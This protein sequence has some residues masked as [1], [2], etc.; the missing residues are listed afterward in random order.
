MKYKLKFRVKTKSDSDGQNS[1]KY[2]VNIEEG[3]S[4]TLGKYVPG[5]EHPIAGITMQNGCIRANAKVENEDLNVNGT[6]GRE[7]TLKPNDV[8]KAGD[9]IVEFLEVPYRQP[10]NP[11]NETQVLDLG[12]LAAH[13]EATRIGK[14]AQPETHEK[15]TAVMPRGAAP[16]VANQNH[17]EATIVRPQ[18]SE[19]TPEE[20]R[21]GVEERRIEEQRKDEQ[22]KQERRFNFQ[23]PDI[24]DVGAAPEVRTAQQRPV[25]MEITGMLPR[26]VQDLSQDRYQIFGS[27]LMLALAC[28]LTS[29]F[30][31]LGSPLLGGLIGTIGFTGV[32]YLLYSLRHITTATGEFTTHLRFMALSAFGF[33]PWAMVYRAS[34]MGSLAAALVLGGGIYLGLSSYLRTPNRKSW[35]IAGVLTLIPFSVAL[36]SRGVLR[37]R[38]QPVDQP[39]EQ[40]VSAAPSPVENTA[41]AV[42]TLASPSAEV[43]APTA[44]TPVTNPVTSQVATTQV[45]PQ[46][47]TPVVAQA[48]DSTATRRIQTEVPDALATEELFRAIR[49]GNLEIVRNLVLSGGAD[50]NFNLERGSTPLMVAAQ[51][52]YDEIVNFLISRKV[53]ID[54]K[55]PNGTTALMWAVV[56]N[57]YTIAQT[58]LSQGANP[59]VA[60][61]NGQ[62]ALDI[63]KRW[64]NRMMVSLLQG[65]RLNRSLAESHPKKRHRTSSKSK[66][67]KKTKKKKT[68]S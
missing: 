43:A 7:F 40:P 10:E 58:L 62:T 23:R 5:V 15:P 12:G 26:R 1:K 57:R 37:P 49:S 31:A 63:A 27:L 28:G 39:V 11:T 44:T 13:Q 22:R 45:P 46:T 2:S 54:A 66:I 34:P 19:I 36:A 30:S 20:R 8:L 68:T 25:A 42:T 48:T 29:G 35:A 9:Y 6:R 33:V 3:Q 52:G 56:K 61:D 59:N 24:K 67:T 21:M 18:S 50:P 51:T 47:T 53:S 38:I 60:R 32:A 65:E 64:N 16:D 14:I 17:N 55:D 4:F 41:Q